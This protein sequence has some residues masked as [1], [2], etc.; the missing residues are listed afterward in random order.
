MVI[1]LVM[2]ILMLVLMASLL[3]GDTVH[4]ALGVFFGILYIAH[5]I[6]NWRWYRALPKGRYDTV[7]ILQTAVNLLLLFDMLAVMVSA[8]TIFQNVFAPLGLNGGVT[9]RKIHM[10]AAYFGFILMSIH[11]GFHWEMFM[12]MARK[13]TKATAANRIRTFVL[14]MA[15]TLIAAYGMYASFS[16]NVSSKLTFQNTFDFWDYNKPVTL[17]FIDYLAIMGLYVFMTHYALKLLR[18]RGK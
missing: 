5:N 12:S 13:L 10:F 7:R 1:D 11:L 15:A 14:R 8:M 16:R 2:I 3:T 17:F 18:N 6:L 4:E 9:G